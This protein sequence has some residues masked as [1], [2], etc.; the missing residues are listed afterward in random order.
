MINILSLIYH[1]LEIQPGHILVDMGCSPGLES[2]LILNKMNN[3]IHIIGKYHYVR[4]EENI[5]RKEG[6]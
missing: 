1:S 3:Q 4:M 5:I 6:Q 2:K